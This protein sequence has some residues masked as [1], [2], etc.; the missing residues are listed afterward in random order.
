MAYHERDLREVMKNL[1]LGRRGGVPIKSGA[2]TVLLVIGSLL[3]SISPAAATTSK[4]K[5]G[6]WLPYEMPDK[7]VVDGL[8]YSVKW[9][10]TRSEVNSVFPETEVNEILRK[11]YPELKQK[12]KDKGL[13]P[14]DQMYLH[15]KSGAWLM[16]EETRDWFGTGMQRMCVEYGN[17]KFIGKLAEAGPVAWESPPTN[18][19]VT[20]TYKF[21]AQ[22][23]RTNTTTSGWSIGGEI[24]ATIGDSKKGGS[25]KASFTYSTST[26]DSVAN[27]TGY[28]Q[29]HTVKYEAGSYKSLQMRAHGGKYVGYLAYRIPDTTRGGAYALMPVSV[30]IKSPDSPAAVTINEKKINL[31]GL[32]GK[33]RELADGIASR[34]SEI[35]NLNAQLGRPGSAPVSGKLFTNGAGGKRLETRLAHLK[36]QVERDEKKLFAA[37]PATFTQIETKSPALEK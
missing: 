5:D 30:F 12:E 14:V 27:M 23:T 17:C 20:S 1:R 26:T 19:D 25:G 10:G 15:G 28:E 21:S 9:T 18:A 11:E 34:E 3:S 24:G 35:R 7:T 6:I 33:L 29:S 31:S 8:P 32:S 2:A 36:K 4:T 16:K 13:S 22:S 37:A